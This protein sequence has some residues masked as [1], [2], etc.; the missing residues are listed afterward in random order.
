[1]HP[2]SPGATIR[3]RELLSGGIGL[4]SL[5][6]LRS[7]R[8]QPSTRGAVVIGV[9]RVGDLPQLRAARSGAVSFADWLRGEGFEVKLLVDASGP[10]RAGDIFSAINEFV[11]RGTLEQLVVYFAGHGFTNAY[12]EYWLLSEGPDNPNEA[13]VLNESA[14]L[15]KQSAIPNVVFVSDACRSR[16][17]SLR[18]ERVRGSIVFPNSGASGNVL[19]DIDLFLATLVGDPSYEVSVDQSTGAFA[20][21]YTSCFLDA[22]KKPYDD[23]VRSVGGQ[24]VVPN[25]RLKPYLAREV[26][27]RAQAVSIALD[28]RPDTQ[29]CSDD[30]TF[31]G[32]VLSD[33][34][35]SAQGSARPATVADIAAAGVGI[36]MAGAD[37]TGEIPAFISRSGFSTLPKERAA[38]YAEAHDAIFQARG[39]SA[40]L[41]A[42]T[43][44]VVSGQTLKSVTVHP[45][46]RT[47]VP[48]SSGP[49]AL[50][51][52]D[53]GSQP[54]ASV[55]LRFGNDR[56]MV[57]AALNGYVANV[58]VDGGVVSNVSYIPSVQ[59][60]MRSVYE[61]EAARLDQL[62]A[63]IG[64]AA[65]FGVFRIEGP[66]DARNAAA[67]RLADRIRMLKRVDPTL[68]LYAAYAYYDANVPGQVR[69]VAGFMRGDLHTDL[70]DVAMLAGGL[71][72]SILNGREGPAPFCPMLAQGW[73]LLRAND[74]QLSQRVGV[75]QDHL[76]PALWTTLDS[77][78]MAIVEA[79]LSKGELK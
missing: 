10:V 62:H 71:S 63:A 16:A 43:G 56:G 35:A 55:A 77:A 24:L 66:R 57:V 5:L 61:S 67:E 70:F 28:Q 3:R 13:V 17:D 26:P 73:S 7:A 65:R 51:E 54:A 9:D 27:R 79:D 29:V 42:R 32:H 6:M 15:A 33:Q 47:N 38:A 41:S 52:V 19:P 78:G 34:R 23:M 31:I 18:A 72:G 25:N 59:N 58:V 50:V 30:M 60:D 11:H 12:S 36:A 44:C 22:F 74:V 45:D 37:V 75:L 1:M 68:G 48:D 2:T 14:A 39:A 53:L 8:P 64:A 46:F 76:A 4:A 49:A 69:S 20:G 40:A 21:I